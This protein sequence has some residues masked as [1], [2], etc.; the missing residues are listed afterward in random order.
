MISWRTSSLLIFSHF[1]FQ[2]ITQP[3]SRKMISMIRALLDITQDR[4]KRDRWNNWVSMATNWV[5]SSP[6]RTQLLA[7]GYGISRL[8]RWHYWWRTHLPMQ[9]TYETQV[10]SQGWEDPLEEGM[11][12]HS[13][14]LENLLDREA[15]S[16]TVHRVA[17]SWTWLKLLNTHACMGEAWLFD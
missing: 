5:F 9:E 13:T 7:T 12:P 1:N 16:A 8:P 2:K 11:E 10:Q 14:C 6:T 4:K 17:K 3:K 15:W